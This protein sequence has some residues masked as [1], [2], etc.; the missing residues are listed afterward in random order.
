MAEI[1]IISTATVGPATPNQSSN[2]IEFTPWELQFPLVGPIQ[3]GLLFLHPTPPSPS[4]SPSP[5]HTI[6]HHLKT[7]LSRTLDFFYPLAGR[8][9][10]TVNNDHDTISFFIDC[11]GA[12]AQFIHAAA[13]G[14]TAAGILESDSVPRIVY[15]F[16]P[17]DGTQNRNGVS[18]PLLAVQVTEL[19]DGIFIGCTINHMIVDGASF[20]HFFNSWSEISR[21]STEITVFPVFDRPFIDSPDHPIRIPR[22]LLV[23]ATRRSS[24][25][26]ERFFHFTKEKIAALKARANTEMATNKISS[27]Q[28]LMAH[29]WRS[30]IRN[31]RLPEDEETMY[32]FPVGMRP[33]LRPPLAPE[34]FGA[35][36]RVGLVRMKVWELLKLGIGHAAWELNKVISTFTEAEAANFLESWG[37]NPNPFPGTSKRTSGYLLASSSPRFN[38]YANDFGWGRPVAVRSGSGNKTGAKTT[39]FPGAEEGSIDV[40]AFL[41]PETLQSMVEDEEFMEALTI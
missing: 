3:K 35:P 23:S 5:D 6:I 38:V 28:A 9:C 25:F 41:M 17:L 24:P 22:S 36:V 12:G 15:S 19:A 40:E 11:N 20:W 13:R 33:R 14:V 32:R 29:M 16:F 39:L 10:T 30:V 2:R 21:G 31:T 18:E 4:P 26:Q 37:K 8:L 34:Y 27:L 1:S 7:S